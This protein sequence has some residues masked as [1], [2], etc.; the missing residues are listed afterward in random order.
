MPILAGQSSHRR[1]EPGGGGEE[2]GLQEG[3]DAGDA[4]QVLVGAGQGDEVAGVG[5]HDLVVTGAWTV[6]GV[7][8]GLVSASKVL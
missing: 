7:E 8:L 2:Q 3:V 1:G 6:G 5:G 4:L